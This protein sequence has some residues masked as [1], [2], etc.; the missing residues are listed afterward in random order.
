MINKTK[1]VLIAVLVAMSAASPA[2]AQAFSKGYGTCGDEAAWWQKI[3]I[4]PSLSARALWFRTAWC[5]MSLY[6]TS[7]GSIYKEGS[8]SNAPTRRLYL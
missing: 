5:L 6:G 4:D 8:S 7:M 2:F 3:G 1:L